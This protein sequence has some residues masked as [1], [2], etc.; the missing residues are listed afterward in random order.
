MDGGGGGLN[1]IFYSRKQSPCLRKNWAYFP[2]YFV[3]FHSPPIQYSIGSV[4]QE[5]RDWGSLNF[6][7][8]DRR[9]GGG[10]TA[11]TY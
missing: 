3:L 4:R 10:G 1:L 11:I 7:E 9:G 8:S 6:S 5:P 2:M